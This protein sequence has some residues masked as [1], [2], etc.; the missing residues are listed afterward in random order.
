MEIRGATIKF[1]A[2]KKKNNAAREQLLIH[3]IEILHFQSQATAGHN[4]FIEDEL[5]LKRNELE[6]LLQVESEGAY[7]RSRAKYNLEGEKPSRLFCNL[8]KYN[9]VQKYV[10]QLLVPGQD[11]EEQLL[12]NQEPIENEILDYY[13]CL[14]SN[15]D[16]L[17]S[18]DSI[19]SFLGSSAPNFPK[20]NDAQSQTME[21][22]I[23]LREITSYLKKM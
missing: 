3:D 16:D 21:G 8:E 9:G 13:K 1:S 11:G 10:P 12:D 15:K 23:T 6:T 4:P 22:N 20:L 7:V 2:T 18:N 17:L 5:T 14:F 19:E